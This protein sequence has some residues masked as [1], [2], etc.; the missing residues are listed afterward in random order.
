MSRPRAVRSASPSGGAAPPAHERTPRPDCGTGRIARRTAR[1]SRRDRVAA[2]WTEY[3][4]PAPWSSEPG[5]QALRIGLGHGRGQFVKPT[6]RS[7]IVGDL[8]RH[9]HRHQRHL[10]GGAGAGDAERFELRNARQSGAHID[11]DWRAERLHQPPDR[12]GITQPDRI[13]AIR[14]GGQIRS[15]ALDGLVEARSFVADV[16]QIEIGPAIDDDR[17]GSRP[18]RLPRSADPVGSIRHAA[19]RDR[20]VR[21]PVL[22]IDADSAGHDDFRHRAPHRIGGLTV[23]RLDI[24]GYR[25]P[26]RPPEAGRRSDD[27]GPWRLFAVGITERPRDASAGRRDR[28]EAGVRKD[29]RAHRVPGVR[30]QQQPRPAVLVAKQL[31]FL[32]LFCLVHLAAPWKW[33]STRRDSLF[34]RTTEVKPSIPARLTDTNAMEICPRSLLANSS[35]FPE[36]SLFW[37]RRTDYTGLLGRI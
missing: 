10:A 36:D 28:I 32:R 14:P 19:D 25:P 4:G 2:R 7:Q 24:G 3:C 11:V 8:A 1:R 15:P 5:K 18:C 26:R 31:R 16:P 17:H 12:H 22:E 33:P 9:R 30:Q 6:G 20:A 35:K 13:D 34:S 23:T 21:R 29:P 37:R 27:L